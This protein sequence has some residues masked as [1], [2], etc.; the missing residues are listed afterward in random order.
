L[1]EPLG[2][3]RAYLA[4]PTDPGG[5]DAV[6]ANAGPLRRL[7]DDLLAL[8]GPAPAVALRQREIDLSPLT[9][10]AADA[11]RPIA[12]AKR[13]P[14]L[15]T[16]V[17]PTPVHADPVRLEQAL[18]HLLFNAVKYTAEGGRVEVCS[19]L[20]AEPTVRVRNPDIPGDQPSLSSHF[21]REAMVRPPGARG[22]NRSLGNV[23]AVLDAHRATIALYDR[24]GDGTSLHVV[25]PAVHA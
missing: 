8:V 23:K 20:E 22:P 9:Q 14:V 24:P 10:R 16:S 2:A 4:A 21:Y 12:D 15:C 25:F 11:V 19:G 3:L 5:W 17:T 6:T 1:R 18:S 7:I 13:I